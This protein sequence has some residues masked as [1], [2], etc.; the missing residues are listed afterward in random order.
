MIDIVYGGAWGDEGKGKVVSSLPYYDLY[1]RYNGGPNAGHTIYVNGE[2]YAVHQL[3]SGAVFNKPCYI[4][5]GCVVHIKKLFQEANKINFNLENLTIHPNTAIITEEHVNSDK[6]NQFK[7][8]GSTGSGIAP[9]YADK[10]ARVA[11]TF[12][13][14]VNDPAYWFL[15]KI[16]CNSIDISEYAIE[17]QILV[18][19]AQGVNLDINHGNYPFVT[20]SSCLPQASASA[21]G[22]PFQ[23]VDNVICVIKA[24]DTRSG[25]DTQFYPYAPYTEELVSYLYDNNSIFK[26]IAELGNEKGVTTGRDRQ[27]SYLNLDMLCKNLKMSL[28]NNI[29]INKLDILDTL[30][31]YK[32]FFDNH[33]WD[34]ETRE[35][36]IATIENAISATYYSLGYNHPNIIW[37][38]TPHPDDNIQKVLNDR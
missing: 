20:S 25:K 13:D 15:E 5:P 7:T 18:E 24:Y 26:Q 3:P 11:R 17:N 32:L 8:Q 9:A 28:P 27:I 36:F 33:L 22:F 23:L 30:N 31:T 10:H 12:V 21:L 16:N 2:K 35:T 14:Y 38:S 37:S 19:A 6:D 1:C 4:G 29:V 34:F